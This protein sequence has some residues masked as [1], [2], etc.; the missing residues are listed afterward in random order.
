MRGERITDDDGVIWPSPILITSWLLTSKC[1]SHLMTQ[2]INLHAAHGHQH[3]YNPILEMIRFYSYAATCTPTPQS[4]AWL[5]LRKDI[6]EWPDISNELDKTKLVKLWVEILLGV[7]MVSDLNSDLWCRTEAAPVKLVWF[8]SSSLVKG[9]FGLS[10]LVMAVI[11]DG[12]VN[13]WAYGFKSGTTWEEGREK[14]AWA[15]WE[16]S[17]RNLN[18]S[19]PALPCKV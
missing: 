1:R 2:K 12:H 3:P 7:Q 17:H 15:H 16:T 6:H 13:L 14:Q 19:R 8:L 4:W 5:G 18:F 10:H 11:Y 9:V